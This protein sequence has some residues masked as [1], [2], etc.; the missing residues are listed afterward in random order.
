MLFGAGGVGRRTTSSD[1]NE[2]HA[3]NEQLHSPSRGIAPRPSWESIKAPYLGGRSTPLGL[4]V[5][6]RLEMMRLEKRIV[7]LLGKGPC[8]LL[9][10]LADEGFDSVARDHLNHRSV[11]GNHGPNRILSTDTNASCQ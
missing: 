6:I 5:P 9:L 3:G 4:S 10:T 11:H 8:K 1:P 2:L 7:S